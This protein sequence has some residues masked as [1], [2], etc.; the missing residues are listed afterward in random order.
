M[1]AKQSFGSANGLANWYN[2]KGNGEREDINTT[3]VRGPAE[4]DSLPGVI[5]SI[6]EADRGKPAFWWSVIDFFVDGLA[7]CGT[8]MHPVMFFMD[9]PALFD[10]GRKADRAMPAG[11]AEAAADAGSVKREREIRR[12]VEALERL[13]DRTLL[14]LGIRHRSHIEQTVRYCHDC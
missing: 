7:S 12:A 1:L 9:Q 6:T 8:S 5:V 13:D 10:I 2:A 14:G 4:P 3:R 11:Y